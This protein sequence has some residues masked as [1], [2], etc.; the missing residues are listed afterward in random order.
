MSRGEIAPRIP[1]S[2]RQLIL[3]LETYER[4]PSHQGA[5]LESFA[6]SG[7]QDSRAAVDIASLLLSSKLDLS[8]S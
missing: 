7:A 6:G 1:T 5:Q 2:T 3:L 8:L 4:A